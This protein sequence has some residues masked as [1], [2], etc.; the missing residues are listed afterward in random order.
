M[1]IAIQKAWGIVFWCVCSVWVGKKS[2]LQ[3]FMKK[4]GLKTWEQQPV[5]TWFQIWEKIDKFLPQQLL[6]PLYFPRFFIMSCQTL[7]LTQNICVVIVFIWK[8]ESLGSGLASWTGTENKRDKLWIAKSSWV[9]DPLTTLSFNYRVIQKKY[10]TGKPDQKD[11]SE[12]LAAAQGLAHMITECDRLF[13]V[14]NR[15]QQPSS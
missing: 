11:L 2:Y 12:N 9:W 10:A 15:F 5:K 4:A 6:L 13:E 3:S 1:A 8:W 14:S 7:P